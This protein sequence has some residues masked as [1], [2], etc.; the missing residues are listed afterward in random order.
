MLVISHIC[1]ADVN[2]N[3]G[4]RHILSGYVSISDLPLERRYNGRS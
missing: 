2:D 4:K 1:Q 3:L